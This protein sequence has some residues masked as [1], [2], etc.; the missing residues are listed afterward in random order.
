VGRDPGGF[1]ASIMRLLDDP[2]LAREFGRNGRDHVENSWTWEVTTRRLEDRLSAAA[3]GRREPADAGP[4]TARPT[5][6][7]AVRQVAIPV[8]Q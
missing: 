1:A 5:S 8:D 7:K 2:G 4:A 6:E 3:C